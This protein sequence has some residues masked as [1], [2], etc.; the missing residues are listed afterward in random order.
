MVANKVYCYAGGLCSILTQGC[1]AESM[2]APNMHVYKYIANAQRDCGIKQKDMGVN[3][4]KNKGITVTT[5]Y[6]TTNNA[7]KFIRNHVYQ[8][9]AQSLD[10][11]QLYR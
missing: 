6:L 11:F 2:H 9:H 10:M 5:E 4:R 8:L 7:T 3:G 1:Y